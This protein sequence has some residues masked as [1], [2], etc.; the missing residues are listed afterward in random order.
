MHT[1]DMT[2]K[3]DQEMIKIISKAERTTENWQEAK[4]N[5]SVRSPGYRE[6]KTTRKWEKQESKQRKWEKPKGKFQVNKERKFVNTNNG[7]AVQ[8]FASRT[9][10]ISQDE[11]N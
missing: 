11:L 4:K 7:S 5:V 3:S 6:E 2:G 10:G 8:M 9:E 1:V